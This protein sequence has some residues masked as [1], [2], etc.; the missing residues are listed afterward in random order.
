MLHVE[1]HRDIFEVTKH[2][3]P[4]WKSIGRNLGFTQDELSSIKRVTGQYDD[5]DFY[6][7]MLSRWL[8]WAPPNHNFPTAQD[9]SSALRKAGKEKHAFALSQK[10]CNSETIIS[11]TKNRSTLVPRRDKGE[12][13]H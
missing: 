5:E 8:D 11:P 12:T 6:A 2:A 3:C 4:K 7:D 9:L 10:Y 13:K 1:D